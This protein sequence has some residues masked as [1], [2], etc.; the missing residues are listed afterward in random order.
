MTTIFDGMDAVVDGYLNLTDTWAGI[1]PRYRHRATILDLTKTPPSFGATNLID[2]LLDCSRSAWSAAD[3]AQHHCRSKENW[4]SRKCLGYGDENLSLEVV[5]ERLLVGVSDDSWWN[6]VP[7]DSGVLDSDGRRH[8]DLVQKEG[9]NFSIIE[10]KW[11]ANTPLS[12][13][14]QV[15]QYGVAYIFF[16]RFV[17]ARLL[18]DTGSDVSPAIMTANKLDLVVLA[19]AAYYDGFRASPSWLESFERQLNQDL[20][21]SEG[22]QSIGIPMSFR[23]ESFPPDFS[24]SLEVAADPTR[25]GEVSRALKQRSRLFAPT[26]A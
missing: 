26:A 6:Q 21:Q 10:L 2:G 16:R 8:I 5:L 9:E 7:V 22:R 11:N 1:A 20:V 12:A 15:I 3:E 23:F 24:W 4:R 13:A 17:L 14:I 18:R 25:H 19:P